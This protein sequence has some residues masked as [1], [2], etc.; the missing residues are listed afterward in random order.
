VFGN[1]VGN[2]SGNSVGNRLGNKSGNKDGNRLGNRL[3]RDGKLGWEIVWV[4]GTGIVGVLLHRSQMS[5]WGISWVG[6]YNGKC[7][8]IG[9]GLV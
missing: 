5:R 1:K 6:K 4:I 7:W 2:R 3:A 9:Q 8:G